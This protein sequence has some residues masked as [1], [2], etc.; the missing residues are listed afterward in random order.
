MTAPSGTH[1]IV[2]GCPLDCPDGCSW[3]VTVDGATPVKLR[4]NRAHPFTRGSLCVKVNSYLEHTRHPDRLLYPM[5]RVGAKGEG[6]FERIGWDDA[7][8][9]WAAR[10]QSSIDEHGAESI[11]PYAGT[12]TV[13]YVQGTPG[14]GNRLFNV[15][16]ASKH[17]ANICS[18]AGHVGM[19]YTTGSAGGMDPQDLRHSSLILL[20]GSNT[21][22]SNQHLWPFIAEARR[23]GAWVVVIDPTRTR[24]AERADEHVALL[25]GTD[26]ALAL[27]LMHVVVARGAHDLAYLEQRTLGWPEFE[28]SLERYTPE[29]AAGQCGVPREQIEALGERLA[30]ARPTGIKLSMGMQ[31]HLGGGQAAR[32]IS[33][34]PAITGDYDR[35]GGGACYSTSP[36]YAFDSVALNRPDLAPGPRR[37]LA[38]TRLGHGLLELDDPPVTCL[39]IYASNPVASNPDQNR[40]RRGLSRNDLHTV[41]IDHFRT[42]TADY[43]DL[44]LPATMQTEH[45]DLH[46][47]YSHLYVQLNV[48]VSAP[49]GE[50][51]PHTEMFRRLATR[52]GIDHPAVHASDE[53]LARDALGTSVSGGYDVLARAGW[54]RL[55]VPSPYQPFLDRFP[56]PSGRFELVS[57]RAEA[58]GHG[59]LPHPVGPAESPA[60][61]GLQLVAAADHYFLNSVFAN[62]TTHRDRSG[63]P[64]VVLNP[65]DAAARGL[66]END[67]VEVHNSRGSF[68]AALR[69]DDRARPGVAVSTK[70]GWPRHNGGANP[71]ATVL[72]RDADMGA[73]AI[74]HDNVVDV[75]PV[76]G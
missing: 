55:D 24:T 62:S 6:R 39:A 49:P 22:T 67:V 17:H 29:W 40:I 51:L 28:A 60:D 64:A 31:R 1:E 61:G 46:D 42:D 13:G 3:I 34:I 44:L 33:C 2:G 57:E 36:A 11:W 73:G 50:C 12:G 52:L 8:D 20:W 32:V 21:L 7:L 75:C 26:A 37:S 35:L 16:G 68:Q 18:V 71:N 58:D 23:N 48:P 72:E 27:A 56:T 5:R 65:T 4:A 45:L 70:G 59:R 14:A 10:L 76:P 54:A 69:V 43:A 63:E 19:S 15:L 30:S 9:E 66:R 38:M 47:S 53:Q 74:F 41:V 25:P